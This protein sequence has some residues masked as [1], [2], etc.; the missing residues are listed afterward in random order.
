MFKTM[1]EMLG[2]ASL[3]FVFLPNDNG[4]PRDC[5]QKMMP[6]LRVKASA[7]ATPVALALALGL[8]LSSFVQMQSYL[9]YGQ[10][11][12]SGNLMRA[13]QNCPIRLK[14]SFLTCPLKRAP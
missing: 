8:A 9:W 3:N 5:E 1:L 2:L 12:R 11:L 13:L 6:R 14:S 7:N 10:Y 4:E